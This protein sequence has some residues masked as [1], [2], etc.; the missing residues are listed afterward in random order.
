MGKG[1]QK[2]TEIRG[3]LDYLKDSEATRQIERGR[4]GVR[5][6]IGG[7]SIRGGERASGTPLTSRVER[8]GFLP[9]ASSFRGHFSAS[10]LVPI[11][12]L[13][14]RKA[15]LETLPLSPAPAVSSSTFVNFHQ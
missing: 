3:N 9:A 12:S 14:L 8:L 5:E 4:D 2:G 1:E 13:Q 11:L 10:E 7:E 15:A 6:A